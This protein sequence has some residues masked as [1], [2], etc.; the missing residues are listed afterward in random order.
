MNTSKSAILLEGPFGSFPSLPGRISGR[1]ELG[2]IGVLVVL[3]LVLALLYG[4]GRAIVL[5]GGL[6]EDR[7]QSSCPAKGCS[8]LA[9]ACRVTLSIPSMSQEHSLSDPAMAS[10][11]AVA[12]LI[13]ARTW[14]SLALSKE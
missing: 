5:S 13:D 4:L 7:V 3:V 12:A 9:I 11:P 2:Q 6:M 1:P 14:R 10:L 8:P